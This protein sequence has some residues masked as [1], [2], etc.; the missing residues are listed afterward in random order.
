MKKALLLLGIA[1]IFLLSCY[2]CKSDEDDRGDALGAYDACR[3]YRIE[4]YYKLKG[5]SEPLYSHINSDDVVIEE[6]YY[7]NWRVE[8]YELA[9]VARPI[10][11]DVEYKGNDNWEVEGCW[12]N[13][14]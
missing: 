6:R 1:T 5:K 8:F 3:E 14:N 2:A 12:D 9:E 13:I 10:Y 11:C 7:R 4:K